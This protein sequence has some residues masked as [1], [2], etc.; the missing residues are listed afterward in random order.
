MVTNPC[1]Q[2]ARAECASHVKVKPL[3]NPQDS[4]FSNHNLSIGRGAKNE[5]IGPWPAAYLSKYHLV[6]MPTLNDVMK[7][8]V[9]ANS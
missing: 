8:M 4:A 6:I 9:K 5:S 2:S 1:S 3:A 7:E